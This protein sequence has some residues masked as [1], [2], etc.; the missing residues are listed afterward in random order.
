[1]EDEQ[2]RNSEQ[3]RSKSMILHHYC[4]VLPLIVKIIISLKLFLKRDE[5]NAGLPDATA[6]PSDTTN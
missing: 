3:S 6:M 1:V 5:Y 4:T 2:N